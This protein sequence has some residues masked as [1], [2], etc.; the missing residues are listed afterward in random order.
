MQK[1]KNRL[2]SIISVHSL[3]VFV[4]CF[5]LCGS[6][7]AEPQTLPGQV[8]SILLP[9]AQAKKFAGKNLAAILPQLPNDIKSQINKTLVR[10][11]C[12]RLG[13]TVTEAEIDAEVR[14]V[15]WL[16]HMDSEQWLQKVQQ[17]RSVSPEQYRQNYVWWNLALVKLAD[18]RLTISETELTERYETQ[19]GPA[20]LVGRIVFPTRAEAEAVLAKIKRDP[21]MFRIYER[22]FRSND[23]LTLSLPDN[24]WLRPPIRRHTIDP[25]VENILFAMELGD[26][27]PVIEH[28]PGYFSIFKCHAHLSQVLGFYKVEEQLR[29]E[30]RDEKLL[31]VAAEVLSELQD[32]AQ[33]KIISVKQI[34]QRKRFRYW[35]PRLLKHQCRNR[36]TTYSERQYYPLVSL[37]EPDPSPL[38]QPQEEK[39]PPLPQVRDF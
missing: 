17:E 10:L 22:E 31:T 34:A 33:I 4:L 32:R 13:I 5:P 38:P 2:L 12:E 7:A 9:T 26:V 6:F 36:I 14:R 28:P 18:L 30:I 37:R 15:A 8:E 24:G 20:I 3:F 27:S 39:R 35:Q 29:R 19:F 11:E 21:G 23:P 25:D 1:R 16:Y